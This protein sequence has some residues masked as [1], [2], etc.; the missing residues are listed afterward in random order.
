MVQHLMQEAMRVLKARWTYVAA[1][2][3]TGV[4]SARQSDPFQQIGLNAGV[5]IALTLGMLKVLFLRC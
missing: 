1:R 5:V 2:V 3:F 4:R